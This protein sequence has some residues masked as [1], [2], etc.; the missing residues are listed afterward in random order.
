MT[1]VVHNLEVLF[2]VASKLGE[3]EDLLAYFSVTIL[4]RDMPD[5]RLELKNVLEY[6]EKL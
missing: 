1:G 2:A 3:V 6:F 4:V 5:F